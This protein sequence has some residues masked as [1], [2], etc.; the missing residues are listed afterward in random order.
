MRLQVTPED[1]EGAGRRPDDNPIARAMR[2]MTG[3][4]WC[5]INNHLIL[6]LESHY[7]HLDLPMR[8]VF[9]WQVHRCLDTMQPFACEVKMEAT[10]Q[11]SR[12][13]RERRDSER[14]GD[15]QRDTERRQRTRRQDERRWQ[16]WGGA[17]MD[18]AAS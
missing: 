3:V 4:P 5:L 2:R 7:C 1:I 18:S 11:E 8:V 9:A 13:R 14:R 17:A 16:H 6:Q 12:R 10:P 15:G